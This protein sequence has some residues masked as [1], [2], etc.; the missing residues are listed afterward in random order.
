M[1]LAKETNQHVEKESL[2][3]EKVIEDNLGTV[4]HS[5]EADE[6]PSLL[7]DENLSTVIEQPRHKMKSKMCYKKRRLML[8]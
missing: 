7:K 4:S 8:L 6:E 1:E 3:V 2:P 5:N